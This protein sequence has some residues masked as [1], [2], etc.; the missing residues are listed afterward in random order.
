MR[1]SERIEIGSFPIDPECGHI[2]MTEVLP[3][4][5]TLER[6]LDAQRDPSSRVTEVQP[7]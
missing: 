5:K 6:E 1:L 3:E 2:L 4:I 7:E